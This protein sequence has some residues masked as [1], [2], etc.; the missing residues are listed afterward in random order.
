MNLIKS[1]FYGKIE[2]C[3]EYLTNTEDTVVTE[4]SIY[5]Y[6]SL[7]KSKFLTPFNVFDRI[8]KLKLYPL[9]DRLEP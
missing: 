2:S 3:R 8:W 7:K 1:S 5:N 4:F 6:G 9:N